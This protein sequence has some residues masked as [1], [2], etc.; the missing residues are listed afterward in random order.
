MC[1]E[2]P[3]SIYENNGLSMVLYGRRTRVPLEIID[4]KSPVVPKI[5][6]GYHGRPVKFQ[7]G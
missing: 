3:A 5:V 1:V 4:M 7:I 2:V 6:D